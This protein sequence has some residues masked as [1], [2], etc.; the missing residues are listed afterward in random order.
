MSYKI[1]E[2]DSALKPY[3]NDIK[4]RMDLYHK[5]RKE[6]LEKNNDIVN[7]ASGADYFG[8]H[9][10]NDGWVYREWAPG[11]EKMYLM[12]DMNEWNPTSLPMT[13]KE[14]GIFELY[15]KG[16]DY[17]YDGCKVKAVVIHNGNKLERI[18]LYIHRVV[19]D[20]KTIAWCGEI[21][22][23]EPYVWHDSNFKMHKKPFIYECHIGMAEE[24]QKVGTFNEFTE[25]IL[26]RIKDLG[27]DTIQIMAIMEHPY[28]GSFGYQVSNFFA[29]SSRFG[30]P[31]ELKHLIDT[32]HGLGIGVLLDP[33]LPFGEI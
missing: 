17:L 4:L 8:F 28:Y 25:N 9:R 15:L 26:P 10:T 13:K 14:N 18:P 2:L 33:L 19:Q 23:E 22:D 24:E 32:A 16:K 31:N 21:V 6:L 30:K 7:F 1:I 12:G 29:V 5:T 11:A 3:E 20:P 27:Y